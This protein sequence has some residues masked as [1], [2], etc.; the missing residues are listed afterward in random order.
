MTT[1][2][3]EI[4]K[5]AE[6]AGHV[7]P[8]YDL[9]SGRDANHVL[10]ASGDKFIAEWNLE[11]N[12]ASPF[13]VKM[14]EAVFAI[15]FDE[16]KQRLFAGTSG[17][18]IHIIDLVLK[19]EVRNLKV[20]SKGIFAIE[21]ISE[22]DLIVVA[23]GDGFLS[24]WEYETL[25][26]VR[27]IK[28]IDLKLRSIYVHEDRLYTCGMDGTLRSF[29][30]PWLNEL[31]VIDAHEGG[32]NVVVI[33]PFKP[34]LVSGGKDGHIRFWNLNEELK[35]VREIPAHNFGIY[36]ITFNPTTNESNSF[37]ISASRD[38][39]IKVWPSS[40]FDE[41]VRIE[42]PHLPAHTH[43]VNRLFWIN[44]KEFLSAGD[45]RKIMRWKLDAKS[46]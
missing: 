8:I 16:D 24:I 28:V 31:Q 41:P 25:E 36:S 22:Q 2:R 1:D 23:G 44:D 38:K 45:D 26:L 43:S 14:E 15:A 29:D 13:S 34:L 32:C 40:T 6:M 12:V 7:G 3:S 37:A 19:K 18:N 42:R 39:T 11:D 21:L 4:K 5:T 46:N 33:H 9:C 20:H 27:H 10:T 30:L 35:M 17:G